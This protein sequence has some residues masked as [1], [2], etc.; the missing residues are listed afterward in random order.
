VYTCINKI[1]GRPVGGVNEKDS[2]MKEEMPK[3]S[4]SEITWSDGIVRGMF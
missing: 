4:T 2:L 3:R 1:E